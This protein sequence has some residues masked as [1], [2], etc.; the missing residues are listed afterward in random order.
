MG[1]RST[2]SDIE[3][4]Q[5]GATH[6]HDGGAEGQLAHE[7]SE[8]AVGDGDG[9]GRRVGGDHRRRNKVDDESCQ[10]VRILNFW[11]SSLAYHTM[12]ALLSEVK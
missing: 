7:A 2:T 9:G 11:K 12:R 5:E 3:G 1:C 8:V 6:G 4:A 10:I